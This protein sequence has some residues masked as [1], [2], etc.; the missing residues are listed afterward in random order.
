M[1]SEPLQPKSQHLGYDEIRQEALSPAVP[2]AEDDTAV[3]LSS[4]HGPQTL[5]RPLGRRFLR[6]VFDVL[7]VTI[8]I[9]FFVFG[10]LVYAY[11]GAAY[12]PGSGSTADMLVELSQYNPTIF[13]VVF[14]ALVGS[15]MKN[16]ATWKVQT[17]A[18][19]SLLEQLMGSQTISGAF[20]T[21]IQLPAFNLLAL[22]IMALWSLSPLGSQASYRV[23]RVSIAY[24]VTNTTITSLP[25]FPGGGLLLDDGSSFGSEGSSY[26]TTPFIACVSS[27]RLL[28]TQ[29]QDLWN[30][31]RLPLIEQL[32]D[33]PEGHDPVAITNASGI[34]YSS[35]AGIP[36]TTLPSTGNTSFT[37]SG[38]Y[39]NLA[40]PVLRNVDNSTNYTDATA[41]PPGG[42]VDCTWQ[43]ISAFSLQIAISQPC[44]ASRNI[45]AGGD[46]DARRLIYEAAVVDSDEWVHLECE[47]STTYIDTTFNC[48]SS[49]SSKCL[50]TTVQRSINP[51]YS[52]NWTSFDQYDGLLPASNLREIVLNAFPATGIELTVSGITTYLIDPDNAI[53]ETYSFDISPTTVAAVTTG[54]YEARMA[55][56]LNSIFLLAA[57]PNSGGQGL[58]GGYT[59]V[60]TL[61]GYQN[62]TG[63]TTVG[64][65]VIRCDRAWL[66]VLIGASTVMCL[67]GLVGGLLRFITLVPDVLG[68]VALAMLPNQF[69]GLQEQSTTWSGREWARRLRGL[70]IRLGDVDPYA[71]IGRVALAGPVD[72]RN[73]GR[74]EKGRYF[75]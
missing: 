69:H 26:I 51:P 62:V 58:L 22:L 9:L 25:A 43:V 27:A 28:S 10:S 24:N 71:E 19:V 70:K 40:C 65:D 34:T 30:N 5:R 49:S 8:G 42:D 23:I 4:S 1:H 11:D 7:A 53:R 66:G 47:L 36:T 50:P 72:V 55:Q 16:I 33:Q 67:V 35:L 2:S 68:S 63:T 17:Q 21:Q 12:E 52:G 29:N 64:H 75:Y 59:G 3:P 6:A 13:P 41:N 61:E 60:Q 32:T 48:V 38:S 74:V 31:L 20:L 18:S 15:A 57:S 56:L 44:S 73:V 14:A 39:I 45:S 37:L 54:D 46:R